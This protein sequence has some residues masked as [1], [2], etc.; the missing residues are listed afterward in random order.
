[1]RYQNVIFDLDGVLVFTDEYHYKAWKTIAD[2]LG[3]PFDETVNNRLRGVSRMESLEIILS[4]TGQQFS[5]A[6]KETIAAEKNEIYKADLENLSPQSVSA[7]TIEMLDSLQEMGVRLAI[8]SSS[9]NAEF[10]LEKTG[11]AHYFEVV[12]SGNTITKTKPDPEVFLLAAQ[13]LGAEPKD[14]LVVEDAYAGVEAAQ[15]GGFD[16]AGMGDAYTSELVTYQIK[17]IGEICDIAKQER[18]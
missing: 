12:A 17:E 8:G 18:D 11:I 1:M 13:L 16:C 2:R 14:C 9:K 6:E 3:I 10:I 5:D 7:D 4:Y 15:S